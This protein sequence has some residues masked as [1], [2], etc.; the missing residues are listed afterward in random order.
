MK[1]LNNHAAFVFALMT[2]V[3]F[4]CSET[5]SASP[6]GVFEKDGCTVRAFDLEIPESEYLPYGGGS[7]KLFPRGIPIGVGS[8][9]TYLETRPDGT[10]LFYTVSDRGPNTNT[11]VFVS[12]DGS[13]FATKAFLIPDN[14]PRIGIIAVS[15]DAVLLNGTK[16]LT[17]LSG[18]KITG[19]PRVPGTVG[20]TGEKA[21]S[22][23]LHV[24][25]YDPEGLDPEGIDIDKSGSLWLCDESG[26]FIVNVD[27]ASGKVLKTIAPGKELPEILTKRTPNRGFE[28]IAVTPSGKILAAVQS[29]L[30][31]DG[32]VKKSPASFIRL[33]LFNPGDNSVKTFAYPHDQEAYKRNSD[34]KIGD[35]A[36]IDESRFLVVEQGKG[37]DK[38]MRNLVYEID[39]SGADDITNLTAKDGKLPEMLIKDDIRALGTAFVSKKLVADLRKLGWTAEKA[40]GL[41]VIDKATIAVCSDNDFGVAASLSEDLM[42]ACELHEDGRIYKDGKIVTDAYSA[43]PLNEKS[44]LWII[45]LPENL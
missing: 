31:V 34:A 8:G 3:Y 6:K 30:D 15:S 24:L 14:T 27:A 43:L 40:E 41:A 4:C 5:A 39:I 33:V 11:P 17:D 36:A 37:K 23:T 35:L 1:H 42:D 28:G 38:K 20:Y 10:L 29:I 9:L 21:L 22:E 25:D 19:L 45:K 7:A 12:S 44:A 13:R 32:S 26:P 16:P 18:R 2:A